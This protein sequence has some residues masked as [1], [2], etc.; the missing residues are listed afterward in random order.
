MV[1]HERN[2]PYWASV[3][4]NEIADNILDKVDLYYK[5][6]SASGRLDRY[7]LAWATYY[8][9]N[10]SGNTMNPSGQQGELTTVNVNHYRNLI[11]HLE[12]LTTSQKPAFEPRATN[13]D[14][15]SQAQVVLAAGLLDYYMSE[16]RL[17]RHIVQSV[18]EGLIYAES[19]VRAYWDSNEG[20]IYGETPTGAPIREGDIKYQN[21]NPM[22]CI[23]D[24]TL[25][26]PGEE[27]WVILRDFQNKHDLAAKF[28]ELA[29]RI[30][31]DTDDMLEMYKT[32]ILNWLAFE[33]SDNIAVYTLLHKPTPAMP[34]G[35]FT[36]CLDNGTVMMDG[37]LPYQETHVYRLAPD[38]ETGTI[39]GYT[40]AF[41]LL[42]IQQ[43]L[44]MLYS[45]VSSNQ[46]AFGVQN[47][48]APKGNDISVSQ[49]ASGMN[50]I[51]HGKD[52]KPEPLD[53]LSTPKEIFEHIQNLKTDAQI[54]AKVDSVTLG[55]PN[56]NLKS[57][58]ALALVSA[59]SVQASMP[60]QRS[61]ASIVEDL[62]TG[63]INI[64]KQ[65]AATPRV[66]AIVG[67]SNRP[68]MQEFTGQDLDL[69]NRVTVDMGDPATRTIGGKVARAE[70][71][72]NQGFIENPDQ[73]VQ[74]VTTGQ[75]E[76]VIQGKQA[77]LL[78]IKSENEELAK[79]QTQRAVITDQHAQHI[80]E[81][82][83]VLASPEVRRDPNS[84]IMAATLAHIQE[85]LDLLRTA[86]P[87]LL[88]L[89]NQQ[90]LAP[91]MMP[92]D[93]GTGQ[94]LGTSEPSGMAPID[95]AQMPN[96][97]SAPPGTD[98]GTQ[99]VIEGGAA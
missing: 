87:G 39:F 31:S 40:V 77:E 96:M 76:P 75:L 94:M 49:L 13:S 26:N 88:A 3:E 67:E 10:L 36:T 22:S 23:R 44:D 93:G 52:G 79:G 28:P 17:E 1:K 83:T 5:Y 71:F 58:S 74:V 84:P 18:K 37:P 95:Q 50:L 33:D 7:R 34:Q 86:D 45:V 27:T 48:T 32:T 82:K 54:I 92:Q 19:F 99:A 43:N 91:Q 61:Y 57:G 59:Q 30:L 35:R 80:L 85:H 6:L 20:K 72:L 46:A 70:A 97:P 29:E 41:D 89:V 64:L 68:L 66:A 12:T 9:S 51:E 81:H 90:S 56:A 53:L 42:P 98:P 25:T 11:G 24:F 63:T 78:L 15:K 60:L 47:L 16:K 2:K 69:I 21:Y 73:Y 38:E 62:G 65:F 8:K 14:A 55:D 4:S